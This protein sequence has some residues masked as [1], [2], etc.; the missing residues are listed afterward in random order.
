MNKG[1]YYALLSALFL[2]S[3]VVINKY[4][5]Q[6]VNPRML[7]FLFFFGVFLSSSVVIA[8]GNLSG[9]Y[10]N[11]RRH[12]KDGIIV[13]GFNAM[14]AT[15]F[16][17]SLS[18]LDAST[19]TFLVRFSTIFIIIIGVFFLKEKLTFYDIPGIVLAI[20]GALVINY[21][22]GNYTSLGLIVALLAALGI[23]L[24]Q[25]FAKI[26]VKR[27]SALALVNLRA[28]FSSL[29][30][31]TIALG[32]SSIQ[33]VPLAVLPVI[34]LAGAIVAVS[35]FAF[36]YKALQLI[37]VSKAAIIRTIDPFIVLMYGLLLFG[38]IPSLQEIIG[39]SLIVIGVVIIIL[40]HRIQEMITALKQ[41]WFG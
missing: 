12:W 14:A 19:T 28:F 29:I 13:G 23:A 17:L 25:V 9:V 32:T 37:D 36:Y 41:P 3:S 26:F 20:G 4:L 21:S 18:L 10:N 6:F 35:G 22:D 16:F 33:P 40:K 31:L 1:Y 5:L 39:G 15:F 11:I 27:M 8:Y 38:T 30:L 2:A 7:A 24:H 34:F